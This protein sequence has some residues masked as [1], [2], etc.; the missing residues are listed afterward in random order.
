MLEKMHKNIQWMT[1]K[2][3]IV[4]EIPENEFWNRSMLSKVN[5]QING[6]M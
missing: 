2:L 5:F 3:K 1:F 4:K 6:Y